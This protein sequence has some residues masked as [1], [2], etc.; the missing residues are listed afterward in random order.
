MLALVFVCVCATA[1]NFP[2]MET[3]QNIYNDDFGPIWSLS[4]HTAVLIVANL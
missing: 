4:Q 1:I 3:I 2:Q